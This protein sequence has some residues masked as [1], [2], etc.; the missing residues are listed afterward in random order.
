MQ[1]LSLFQDKV[2]FFL[3]SFVSQTLEKNLQQFQTFLFQHPGFYFGLVVEGH[4]E[5]IGHRAA[6]TEADIFAAVDHPGN[7]GVDDGA[8]AH[9]T[10]KNSLL[11]MQPK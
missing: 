2:R 7:P 3:F 6:G 9:G 4:S 11:K 8:G 10:E 5:Q 1:R